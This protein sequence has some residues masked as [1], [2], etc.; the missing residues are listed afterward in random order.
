M[1][2]RD[3]PLI[4]QS[5]ILA[6][7]AVLR[8]HVVHT[9]KRSWTL[10]P[11][12][13]GFE[14]V[15]GLFSLRGQSDNQSRYPAVGESRV[16]TLCKRIGAQLG[17]AFEQS[18]VE[19][20]TTAGQRLVEASWLYR[21][22]TAEPDPD[23]IVID[24]R[25]TVTVGPW[26][27]LF[28]RGLEWLLPAAVSSALFRSARRLHT[29]VTQRPVQ[30]GSLCLGFVGVAVLL[31]AGRGEPS[32][33]LA[34]VGLVL[35]VV[36]LIGSRITWSWAELRETRG[37]QAIVAAFEPPEPPAPADQQAMPADQNNSSET[38]VQSDTEDSDQNNVDKS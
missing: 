24:L 36:A 31:A 18:R 2:L 29:V 16:V 8:H 4:E 5:V 6:H 7:L 27:T 30:L 32:V 38:S 35:A 21:W 3:H 1:S 28:Q 15:S 25:E 14:R 17:A 33:P 10:S 37:Y 12:L 13:R 26:L 11:V 9:A 19:R 34:A 20:L 22:L 23:V